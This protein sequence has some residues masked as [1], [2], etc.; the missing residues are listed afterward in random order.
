MFSKLKGNERP[1]LTKRTEATEA[2]T[3]EFPSYIND[4]SY[5]FK[6][7]EKSLFSYFSLLQALPLGPMNE[8]RRRKRREEKGR[9][10]SFPNG[11]TW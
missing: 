3:W 5:S 4:I 2:F 10:A 11:K 9:G 1:L 7:N 6:V 8:R